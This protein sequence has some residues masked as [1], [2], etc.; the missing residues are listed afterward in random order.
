MGSFF[1]WCFL[2]TFGYVFWYLSTFL[3]Q[4]QSLPPQIFALFPLLRVRLH[5]PGVPTNMLLL[6]S[7]LSVSLFRYIRLTYFL[8][9]SFLG[10]DRSTDQSSLC[11]PL[12][13]T[14]LIFISLTFLFMFWLPFL[15]WL[16]RAFCY[17][18]QNSLFPI[19]FL[20]I[21][22]PGCDLFN[23]VLTFSL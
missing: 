12:Y 17:N 15:I 9:F 21:S 8:I 13:F 19:L 11:C 22:L 1:A 4:S 6:V 7:L 10:C 20:I 23:N 3:E 5:M 16:C 18:L 14:F 2:S